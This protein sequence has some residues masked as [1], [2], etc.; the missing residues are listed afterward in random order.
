MAPSGAQS[1]SIHFLSLLTFVNNLGGP[2]AALE[3]GIIDGYLIPKGSIIIANLWCV[4][5]DFRPFF[6][7]TD[8][9]VYRNM[10]HDPE[11]YPEPFEFRPKR[12]IATP[13][14]PAQKNPRTICFGFGRRVC[15]GMYLADTS[16]FS[17]VVCSLAVF[18]IEKAVENGVEITPIHE[19]TSGTIR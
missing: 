18:N 17:L 8:D 11:V 9:G 14:K 10:L 16:I 1:T 5:L 3:D 13:G 7:N 15:P 2:H 19:N 6:S 4:P 12:H